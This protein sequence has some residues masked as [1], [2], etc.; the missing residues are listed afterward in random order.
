MNKFINIIVLIGFLAGIS[1]YIDNKS[2]HKPWMNLKL[3]P[4][5]RA[6]ELL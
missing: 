6:Q 4:E 1:F 2:S 3:T 5:E